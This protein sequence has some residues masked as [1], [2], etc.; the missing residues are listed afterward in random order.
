MQDAQ[1]EKEKATL[2]TRDAIINALQVD[3]PLLVETCINAYYEY[4]REKARDVKVTVNFGDY[5]NPSFES[6]VETIGKARSGQMMSVEAAVEE[7]YGDDKDENWKKDEVGRIKTEL[8][9][10]RWKNHRQMK[11]LDECGEKVKVLVAKRTY[12]MSRKKYEELLEIAKEQVPRG[13]YAIE[14]NNYAE[15]RNDKCASS[16]Q[17]KAMIRLF[18]QQGFKVHANGR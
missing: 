6:Q 13:I 16:A 18:K 3:I 4:I 14:K 17:L 9:I 5:A 15:L 1:R 11:S 8:G 7:L 12:Q 10:A 2:Y